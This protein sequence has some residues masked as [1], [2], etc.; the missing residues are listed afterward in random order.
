MKI[1]LFQ[2][3]QVLLLLVLFVYSLAIFGLLTWLYTTDINNIVSGFKRQNLQTISLAMVQEMKERGIGR[4]AL[5]TEQTNWLEQRSRV[6]GIEMDYIDEIDD[7]MNKVDYTSYE[8]SHPY[9]L[10]G[11]QVGTVLF[12][13]PDHMSLLNPQLED[14]HINSKSRLLLL[15]LVLGIVALIVGFI[16]SRWTSRYLQ[17]LSEFAQRV[18]HGERE[19]LLPVEGT[20][21]LRQLALILNDMLQELNNQEKWRKHLLEDLAHELR[22]P[23]MSLQ[24]QVEAIMDG[25]YK[26]DANRMGIIHEEIN[27][28]SR[29]L[30]DLMRLSEAEGAQF[31]LVLKRVDL[32]QLTRRVHQNFL[33]QAEEKQII[34]RFEYPYVPCNVMVDSDKMIQIMSNIVSNAIKYTKNGG[35][36]LLSLSSDNQFHYIRFQDNGIGIKKKDIPLIFNRFYRVDKSRSRMTGGV[37]I[38]LSI[39]KALAN[40]QGCQIHVESET[41]VGSTFTLQIPIA[42]N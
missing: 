30:V 19:Q 38:G 35:D 25:I 42:M 17:R 27:R 31:S 36:V 16:L 20:L 39:S 11:H 22:T 3:T 24:A 2:K 5:T 4:D 33:P 10:N 15:L 12:N 37:G 21:E 40:A 8:L 7:R 32:I 18:R 14:Y 13:Y 1:N 28:L 34:F 6:Y 23:L 9:V 29:L 26:P 41:G